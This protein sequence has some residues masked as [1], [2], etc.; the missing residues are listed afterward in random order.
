MLQ[1]SAVRGGAEL[2]RP[3]RPEL[4]E[5]RRAAGLVCGQGGCRIS[6]CA[7]QREWA[8]QERDREDADVGGGGVDVV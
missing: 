1:A 6:G 5:R 8:V 2:A 3:D 7:L 4:E